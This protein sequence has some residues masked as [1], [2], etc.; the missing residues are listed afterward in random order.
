VPTPPTSAACT[1]SPILVPSCGAWWGAYKVPSVGETWRT[2]ITHLEGLVG[3]KFDIVYRYHDMS[4]A[5]N[6][7]R[8]PDAD[9]KALGVSRILMFSW[10]SRN[11]SAGTQLRWS[12]IAAGTYDASVIDPEAARLAAYPHKVFLVFDP[13]MDGRIPQA[14]NPADYVAAYRH[15]WDRFKA[16]GVTNAIWVWTVSGYSGHNS[17]YPSLYPGDQYVDWIGYDPYNF[18]SCHRTGWKSFD[19]TIDP[20]YRWLESHGYGD[21]PFMLPEYGT[22]ADPSDP[23]ASGAWYADSPEVIARHPNI[24]ALLEW[25]DRSQCNTEL[26][27]DPGTLAA[28]A[29]AGRNPI[30]NQIHHPPA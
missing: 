24:K 10:A 5:G 22:V 4:G 2:D 9:E 27:V 3:R 19:R 20:F 6:Q 18:A 1:V 23:T 13:E 26:T 15:I 25:D 12:D 30:F 7:G 8:F 14:G 17:Q 21:K 11:F 28:F 29:E 16:D